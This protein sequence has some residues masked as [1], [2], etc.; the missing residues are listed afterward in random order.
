[1][2]DTVSLPFSSQQQLLARLRHLSRLETDFILL[3]GPEGAGKT[4]LANLFIEQASLSYPVILDAKTLDSHVR[5][6]E[7]L[8][9]HWFPGAIFDA[10]D[11]LVDSMTRLLAQS[12]HKRLLV[13][14]NGAWLTDIQLQELVQLYGTLPA[15]VR[16]FMLLLGTAEWAEQVRQQLD[17]VMQSQMLE[18]EVPPLTADDQQQLW[19]ALKFQPPQDAAQDIHYPGQV[20]AMMEPQ[21]NIQ[22]YRQLLEQKSVKALLTVLIVVLLLI[23]IVSL[24]GGPDKSELAQSPQD[25]LTALPTGIPNSGQPLTADANTTLTNTDINGEAVV[26]P[27]ANPTLPESPTIAATDTETPDD[28]DKERVVI[29]DEVVN[30]LMQRQPNAPVTAQTAPAKPAAP[31]PAPQA[32]VVPQPAA[33]APAASQNA[34][35][36]GNLGS[37]ASLKQRSGQ[38]YTLQLM[39][40]RNKSVLEALVSQHK[41]SPAWVYPRTIDGQPWFVLVQG[42]YVSAKQARDAVKGL[43]SELQ[44]AKPWPKP[45]GQVQ[46][47][48]AQ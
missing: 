47:E 35:A 45:F 25:D 10:Q 39:A 3:T 26:Q 19:Q 14:D 34:A 9:S 28:G 46:K 7:A 6:R 40:G 32:P 27:W 29:E 17:E 37:V 21:M 33:Q 30:Q 4:H 2:T 41:L 43:A 11:S 42:D 1:M 15:A 16:P 20:I 22:D 5:F 38:R 23:V 48:V 44:A 31:Q 8:L 12:L 24:T 36:N 13:V 18:V